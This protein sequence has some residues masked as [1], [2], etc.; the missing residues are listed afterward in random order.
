MTTRS[1]PNSGSS[2]EKKVTTLF[3]EDI[4]EY[5][6]PYQVNW[7]DSVTFGENVPDW[8]KRL[9]EGLNATT[10]M[11]GIRHSIRVVPGL[12]HAKRNFGA[13][14]AVKLSG[15]I[16]CSLMGP[17][18][19]IGDVSSADADNFALGKFAQKVVNA[20]AAIQGG[21]VLGELRQTL[22][23][24][25]NPAR[26]L[27][28]L[29][30][31][32]T[33]IARRIRAARRLGPL[34]SHIKRVTENLADAWLEVQFGWKPLLND[35]RNADL[36]LHKYNVGQSVVTRR[37]TSAHTIT[38]NHSYSASDHEA[39]GARYD[40]VVQGR[41][42]VTVIYRGAVRLEARDPK[43]MDPALFGFSP[44]QFLPTIYELAPWSFLIDYFS[45]IGGVVYGLSTLGT[46]LAWCNLTVRRTSHV[47]QWTTP[48]TTVDGVTVV[49]VPSKV[50]SET[51]SVQRDTYNG[52]LIPSVSF[53]IPGFRSLK[54]LNIAA[55]VANRRSD[56]TWSYD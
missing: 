23:T 43:V 33:D 54:W 22:Q 39:L 52:L 26:G 56:R 28:R 12:H 44:E 3:G 20:Q 25:R 37:I 30:D 48:T 19:V 5:D 18:P 7:S 6:N 45:N 46:D 14:T 27:R 51:V 35:I 32:W 53:K 2:Y 36:A 17:D 38:G 29:V 8:R 42:D 13:V 9:R 50:I 49:H 21:V 55:L 34:S 40:S 24:I 10:S 41:K 31:D 15:L 11:S 4:I 1:Y 47:D 16:G